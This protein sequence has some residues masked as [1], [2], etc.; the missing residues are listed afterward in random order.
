MAAAVAADTKAAETILHSICLYVFLS[1][2]Q[3]EKTT[4]RSVYQSLIFQAASANTG[5]QSMLVELDEPALAS[6]TTANAKLLEDVVRGFGPFY[7]IID[8][9]DEI[10]RRQR[11]TILQH[12]VNLAKR[13]QN[14]KLLISARPEDDIKTILAANAEEIVIHEKNEASIRVY[15]N[16]RAPDIVARF[17]EDPETKAEIEGS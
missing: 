8:G 16:T 6:S 7:I 12:L 14:V 4:A 17:C 3:G 9:L 2:E 11:E 5:L 13:S 10:D 15:V 1:F